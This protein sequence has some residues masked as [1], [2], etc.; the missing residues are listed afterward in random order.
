MYELFRRM[1]VGLPCVAPLPPANPL[2]Q[3]SPSPR[4]PS[5]ELAQPRTAQ[6]TR[7]VETHLRRIEHLLANS[8]HVLLL[9]RG[10]QARQGLIA[11]MR[12]QVAVT[13]EKAQAL[14]THV[15]A[16]VGFLQSCGHENVAGTLPSAVAAASDEAAAPPAGMTRKRKTEDGEEGA[17]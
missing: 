9:M 7:P 15:A 4:F 11:L 2:I 8:M 13:R 5:T 1:C 10:Y 3:R 16:A 6:G 14:E 12:K 17:S